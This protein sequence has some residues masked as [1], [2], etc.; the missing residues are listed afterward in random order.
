[1]VNISPETTMYSRCCQINEC[2]AC[3]LAFKTVVYL[4][5]GRK[6]YKSSCDWSRYYTAIIDVMALGSRS[7]LNKDLYEKLY[8]IRSAEAV[9]EKHYPE[10]EMKVPMHMSKGGEAISVGVCHAL[11][12]NAQIFSSYRSH[13]IYL[14]LTEETDEFFAEMYGKT[15]GMA[16]GKAGSMHLS[17]L[18]SGYMGAS[19]IVASGIPL[20]VGAAFANKTKNSQRISTVFLGDGALDEGA[21]W[22]SLNLACAKKLPVLFVCED[23]SFAVH[24]PAKE[25]HGYESIDDIVSQFDCNVISE[26]TTD[27]EVVYNTTLRAIELLT[28]GDK[29]V[30]LHLHYYRYLAHVG[31]KEDFDKGYRSREEFEKWLEIDPVSLQRKKLLGNGVSES[32]IVSIEKQIDSQVLKSKE[33][34]QGDSFPDLEELYYGVFTE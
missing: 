1:M 27:V 12:E 2:A 5:N 15:T 18:E 13:G 3:R 28:T 30:F 7:K 32:E 34:A 26:N 21:F 22:E 6:T 19:A 16:K 8:L 29:P 25:R 31:V 10:D 17:A 23:N 20:A 24:S 9:I 14:A 33:K 11:G 4:S